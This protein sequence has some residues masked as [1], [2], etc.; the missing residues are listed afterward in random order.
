MTESIH[1]FYR[2]IHDGHFPSLNDEILPELIVTSQER[3]RKK[4]KHGI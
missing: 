2:Y 3:E 1:T 4:K